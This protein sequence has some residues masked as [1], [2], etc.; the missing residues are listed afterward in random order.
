MGEMERDFW[1]IKIWIKNFDKRY[2]PVGSDSFDIW[3]WLIY[4]SFFF[5]KIIMEEP[6]EKSS[7]KVDQ[8]NTF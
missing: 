6:P 2:F 5:R 1:P 7:Q 8:I 4:F 3:L